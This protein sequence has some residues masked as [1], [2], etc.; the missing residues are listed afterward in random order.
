MEEGD[1]RWNR[2]TERR[3]WAGR[4]AA[5]SG[6][7]VKIALVRCSCLV[8]SMVLSFQTAGAQVCHISTAGLNQSRRVTGAIHAECPDQPLHSAP[9]GN[10]GVTS[11]FGQKGNSHQFD[12]W[13]HNARVCDNN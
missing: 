1:T 8:I 13:C 2:S 6:M 5:R 4:R 3:G 11:N 12:G 9:F 7:K 10:W